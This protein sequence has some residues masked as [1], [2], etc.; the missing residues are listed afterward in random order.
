MHLKKLLLA[1]VWGAAVLVWAGILAYYFA[2][3][4]SLKEWTIAVA[5]G[6]IALEIAFWTTAAVL[7]VTLWQ[8]RK[9]VFS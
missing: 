3:D 4:P 7:G 5:V 1:F 8:S 2:A 6:A 9:A